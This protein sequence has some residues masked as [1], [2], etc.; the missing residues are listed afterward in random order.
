MCAGEAG[1]APGGG[2]AEH[3]VRLLHV[4]EGHL[5]GGAHV[6]VRLVRVEAQR[7]L[8]VRLAPGRAPPSAQRGPP[9]SL[10][11]ML[12]L[13]AQT[14]RKRPSQLHFHVSA[15]RGARTPADPPPSPE[16]AASGQLR[17][18]ALARQ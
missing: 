11:R 14:R 2:V 8:A 10:A 18:Q 5:R 9:P 15:E 16:R 12:R 3:G 4:L 7:Q 13:P 17:I 1:R 6:R